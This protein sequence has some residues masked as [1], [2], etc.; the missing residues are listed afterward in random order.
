MAV[1]ARVLLAK[2]GTAS[3]VLK[4]NLV[5]QGLVAILE[6]MVPQVTRAP[7]ALLVVRVNP[8]LLDQLVLLV[9]KEPQVSLE[10]R[11]IVAPTVNPVARVLMVL[12]VH[13]ALPERT[14]SRDFLV[15]RV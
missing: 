8:A 10:K 4:E 2:S 9:S 1:A 5:N 6:L 3:L 7:R 12:P 11:V 15:Q 14:A 13:L